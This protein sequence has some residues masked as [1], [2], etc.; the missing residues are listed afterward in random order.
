[1]APMAQASPAVS[2]AHLGSLYIPPVADMTD[3]TSPSPP[4]PPQRQHFSPASPQATL[5]KAPTPW[6]SSNYQQQQ[7]QPQQQPQ[8]MQQVR[9]PPSPAAVQPG[10]A[11]IIP[12]QVMGVA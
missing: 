12:I 8:Y 11:R 7:Q 9:Q 6:M 2:R 1:M 10:G 3:S 4:P 5:N